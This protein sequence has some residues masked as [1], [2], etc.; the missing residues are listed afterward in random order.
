LRIPPSCDVTDRARRVVRLALAVA[1][2][3]ILSYVVV[4]LVPDRLDVT[5]DIVGYPTH[6]NFNVYRYFQVYYS[7][8][9]LFP[10]LAFVAFW[11]FGRLIPAAGTTTDGVDGSPLVPESAPADEIGFAPLMFTGSVYG[12]A[13]AV[14]VGVNIPSWAI[15]LTVA[16]VYALVVVALAARESALIPRLSLPGRIAAANAFLASLSV[17]ALYAVASSTRVVISSTGEVR[18]YLWL[19]LWVALTGTVIAGVVFAGRISRASG[20]ST[21]KR[22]ER[23]ALV[24]VAAP[25]ALFLA[26]SGLPGALGELDMFHPGEWLVPAKLI[27]DGGVVPWRDLF[28]IHGL[29][30]DVVRPG[31]GFVALERSVWGTVAGLN[32]L[33]WPLYWVS[34]YFLNA[35]LFRRNLP[36]LV[37]T[38]A[39]LATGIT[40][41]AHFRVILLPPVLLLLA[42]L[43]AKATPRRAAAFAFALVV[44]AIMTPEMSYA[45]IACG[46]IVLLYE[47]VH[48][49]QSTASIGDFTRTIW[50]AGFGLTFTLVW[51][52]FL[53]IPGAADDFIYYYRTFAPDH[54][55]TGGIPVKWPGPE[56]VWAVII[57]I[58]LILLAFSYVVSHRNRLRKLDPDDWVMGSVAILLFLYYPKFL[59]RADGHIYH[60]YAVAVPLLFYVAYKLL[61]SADAAILLRSVT[62]SSSVRTPGQHPLTFVLACAVLLLPLTS[63][64]TRLAGIERRFAP[65]VAEAPWLSQLGFATSASLDRRVFAD[66]TGFFGALL[67]PGD[68][69]FDFANEPAL[70]FYLLGLSPSTRY[71]HVSMAIRSETQRDLIEQ[72]RRQPPRIVIFDNNLRFGLPSWDGIPNMVRHY[73]VSEYLLENYRPLAWIQGHLL[74]IRADEQVP[75]NVMSLATDE[76]YFRASPCNWG[77]SPNFVSPQPSPDSLSRAVKLTVRTGSSVLLRGWA[78][79]SAANRPAKEVVAVLNGTVIKRTVPSV[80]RP[81][82]ASALKSESI[83]VS[84][85]QMAVPF[86]GMDDGQRIKV[87]AVSW[88]GAA[89]ELLYGA[90]AKAGLDA[91]PSSLASIADDGRDA[92]PV[93]SKGT[94]GWVDSST[95][96]SDLIAVDLPAGAL[97]TDFRWVE[98]EGAAPFGDASLTLSDDLGQLSHA[99]TFRTLA[100][101][102]DRFR[103]SV[104][105]CIQWHGYRSRTLYLTSTTPISVVRLIP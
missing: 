90:A 98:I 30:E 33:G 47:F 46:G 28:F 59:S 92:I 56:F 57:P 6:S 43:I 71:Y 45:V 63:P 17:F 50:S 22:V 64:A 70:S 3:A 83:R 14:V 24:F 44:L 84:G 21:A 66:L 99:I 2:A 73:L 85:Y 75:A 23:E 101:A 5:T 103:V 102:E 1:F 87:F 19:P 42:A 27:L 48:R 89:T 86:V 39:L 53:A 25:V 88:D 20:T 62:P 65:S 74:M 12:V 76:L 51:F 8:V 16:C 29:M 68:V 9:L 58:A 37:L 7:V 40:G 61:T 91:L 38:T 79:D 69:V 93:R 54:A 96:T 94:V 35:Y 60:V 100:R 77:Y 95:A 52:A 41:G 36:F 26:L 80:D 49:R 104:A 31:L 34:I 81:D 97:P 32:L 11:F 4:Q 72:L 13:A 67:R 78:A 82:V 15:V 18:S 55:L 10:L 105:S